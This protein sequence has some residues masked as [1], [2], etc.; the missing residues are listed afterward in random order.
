MDHAKQLPLHVY[1]AFPSQ[2]K[3]SKIFVFSY[4]AEDG[5]NDA[6][7]FAVYMT[8]FFAVYFGDH[9]LGEGNG[10]FFFSCLK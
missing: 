6:K 9:F 10:F 1:F 7:P 2:S 5:F 8:S 4:V 3:P